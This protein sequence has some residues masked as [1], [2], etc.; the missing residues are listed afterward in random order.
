[1]R[2][3]GPLRRTSIGEKKGLEPCVSDMALGLCTG[4]E[5]FL[6]ESPITH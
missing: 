2:P 1:M 3:L 6:F 4:K 5:N